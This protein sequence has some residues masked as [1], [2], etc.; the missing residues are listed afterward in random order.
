M[1]PGTAMTYDGVA[2]AKDRAD[3]LAYLKAAEARPSAQRFAPSSAETQAAAGIDALRS[4]PS[5]W[6][7]VRRK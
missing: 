7:N 5:F 6:L 1:V 2:D 3:L 4:S